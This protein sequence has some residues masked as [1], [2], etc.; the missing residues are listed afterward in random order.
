[1]GSREIDPK[2]LLKGANDR[3]K[4]L[5]PVRP[6]PPRSEGGH[7]LP[8][9]RAD[10]ARQ[11]AVALRGLLL[12]H[13][14]VP[15]GKDALVQAGWG[16]LAVADNNLT[17]QIAALRRVLGDEAG[18]EGWIETLARRGYRYVGP[19]VTPAHPQSAGWVSA[20]LALPEKPSVAVLPFD[21]L[22]VDPDQDYFANGMVD[23]IITGLA[24]IK[25]L[26]VIARN[27]TLVY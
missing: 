27:S 20:A 21:N 13:E 9:R 6:I 1:M 17:V 19:A 23:D 11:R 4:R 2:N 12:E 8:G 24:R 26:F 14:G 16:G 18:A 7:P 10:H 5:L 3:G 22:S 15:V 25:W